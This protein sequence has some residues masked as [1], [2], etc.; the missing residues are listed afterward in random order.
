VIRILREDAREL[1][2]ALGDPDR[3]KGP[4]RTALSQDSFL[5]LAL[6]RLRCSARRWRIPGANHLLR[7]VQTMVFGIELGNDIS[8][9]RGVFF[10][11]PVGIVVGGDARVG[12]RVRFMGSNTVGT[13][14]DDGC[15]VIE[16][17][18]VL[19]A[20]ARVLGPVRVGRNA[21]IGANAVVLTD[22]P[23][24]SV[25]VGMP[26]RVVKDAAAQAAT[27]AARDWVGA[28]P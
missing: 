19:G 7:R 16:D 14:R 3:A 17:D 10:V 2:V 5:I 22:I 26:A 21:V 18:V 9:G 23:P 13:A 12:D 8:L 6:W 24:D 15:P 1:A 28:G 4:M 25:A 20:G 27:R 11:H